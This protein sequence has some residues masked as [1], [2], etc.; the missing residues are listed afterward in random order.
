MNKNLENSIWPNTDGNLG[1]I[2]V[3]IP[4]G[5]TTKWPE[6]DALV[7]NFVYQ[8]GKL[9][10]FVDT[11]ALINNSSKSSN[12]P[13]DYVKIHLENVSEGDIVFNLA[14][15]TENFTVTYG[16]PFT[17]QVF[18]YKG[19]TT[20]AEVKTVDPDYLTND[21]VDGAWTESLGDLTNGINMFHNCSN[22]TT[23]SSN[24]SSLE[25]GYYMF[26]G[27]SALTTFDA[28]LSSLMKCE[29]MFWGCSNLT[30]FSSDLPSL[31]EGQYMFIG[32]SAL[33]SFSSDL[34]KL[35][36][37]YNMFRECDNLATFNSNLSKLTNGSHMFYG[38]HNLTSFNS[39]LSSLTNG[40]Y[41]FTSCNALTSFASDLS[42]LTDGDEMFAGCKLDTASIKNIA[43]TIAPAPLAATIH[44]GIGTHSPT[45][46]ENDYLNQI[47]M[48]GW[49]VYVNGSSYPQESC[50]GTC[51]ASLS[52]L[53]ENGEETTE[54][55]IPYWAKP[56]PATE[57]TAEFV[58]EQGNYYNVLGA[59]FIY[60][61]DPETYGMFLNHEDAIANMRLKRIGEEEIETA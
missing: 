28:D 34:S 1:N 55:P 38:C 11:K 32:C 2:K 45:T 44:I 30:S 43:D 16:S 7:D 40:Y 60:V 18:K 58:D 56:V 17:E 13:Y 3:E 41:M 61:S 37:G 31:T 57:E 19:C 42:S 59:Q 33:T 8:E 29:Q 47:H 6:G 22:L 48:K 23:F 21:I 39:D 24:L 50:C 4:D 51:W 25:Y 9:V 27:C 5:V 46:S 20:V 35:T 14:P 36:N 10:G 49:N 54:T 12:I 52:T 53:D 26:M 15:N